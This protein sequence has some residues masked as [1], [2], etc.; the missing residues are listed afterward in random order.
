M[1]KMLQLTALL[2]AVLMILDS[3]TNANYIRKLSKPYY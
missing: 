3:F 2:L 1:K